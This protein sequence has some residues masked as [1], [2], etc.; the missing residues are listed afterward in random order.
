MTM[1][2]TE[3]MAAA[4]DAVMEDHEERHRYLLRVARALA[5]RIAQREGDMDTRRVFDELSKHPA[6][7]NILAAMDAGPEAR[8]RWLGALVRSCRPAVWEWTGRRAERGSA[9]RGT[10]SGSEGVKVWRL[11]EGADVSSFSFPDGEPPPELP[12]RGPRRRSPR[13]L[14]ADLRVQLD[15]ARA[16]SDEALAQVAAACRGEPVPDPCCDE[17]RAVL[18]LRA[19]LDVAEGGP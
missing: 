15:A 11:V 4:L 12:N 1:G 10:H 14:R 2:T 16:F 13:A 17:V 19:R 6:A 8:H 5:V 3:G 9:E 7:A 18:A